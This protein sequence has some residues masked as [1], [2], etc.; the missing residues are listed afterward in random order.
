MLMDLC[1]QRNIHD[2]DEE[3][4]EAPSL[5]A[6]CQPVMGTSPPSLSS[7]CQISSLR[8]EGNRTDG[9]VAENGGQTDSWTNKNEVFTHYGG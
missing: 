7:R 4:V 6:S 1:P 8:E 3:V 2:M 9:I 5:S